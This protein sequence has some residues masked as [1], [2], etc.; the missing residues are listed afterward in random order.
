MD[1]LSSQQ[2]GENIAPF[3]A[4][5]QCSAVPMPTSNFVFETNYFRLFRANERDGDG[6]NF[7]SNVC[8]PLIAADLVRCRD[9]TLCAKA[10]NRFAIVAA[11]ARPERCPQARD[12][13]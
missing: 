8:Y 11:V 5:C 9:L 4:A 7:H 10:L 2:L 12:R 6:V 1:A 3:A 13:W